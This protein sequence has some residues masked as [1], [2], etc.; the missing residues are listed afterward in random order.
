MGGGEREEGE[1]GGEE[2]RGESISDVLFPA[3]WR[4]APIFLWGKRVWRSW[5][6]REEEEEEEEE[7][8]REISTW[9]VSGERMG[10]GA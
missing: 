6:E 10:T 9:W 1:E 5:K 7:E 4:Y 8:G 2:G 3:H